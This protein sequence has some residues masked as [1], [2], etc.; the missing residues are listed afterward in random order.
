M[1]RYESDYKYRADKLPTG[2]PS[3]SVL[4]GSDL[5]LIL[6][7]RLTRKTVYV[8]IGRQK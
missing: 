8:S 3:Q 1:R 7:A 5:S 2:D 4:V 6:S